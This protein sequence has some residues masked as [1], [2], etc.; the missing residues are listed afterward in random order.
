MTTDFSDADPAR[1]LKLLWG[2][3]ARPSRGPKPG[4]S[5]ERIVQAAI[6]IADAEGL[7]ALSMRR[8]GDHLGAGTMS[9]YRYVPGKT[10]LLA[11]MLD[12]VVGEFPP[13]ETT[14]GWR[15]DLER[16]ARNHWALYHRHPWTLQLPWN[17]PVPG[18]NMMAD[19]EWSLRTV[20]DLGLPEADVV[21]LVHAVVDYVRGAART[22]VEAMEAHRRGMS[23][24]RFWS[25]TGAFLDGVL[26][27]G[28]YP[29]VSR[30]MSA[31]D[32]PPY[33]DRIFEFGLQRVLDGIE[34]F[35]AARSTPPDGG[36]LSGT[37][38]PAAVNQG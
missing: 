19:Y 37:G 21:G 24:E 31:I 10:E 18:P 1:S 38:Q 35:I 7:A 3:R 33:G 12:A 4:L 29:A 14:G 9:L 15:A 6:D 32:E 26:Q 16:A 30:I 2:I 8:V 11:L 27:T 36:R 34:A 23:D 25:A 5:I 22:S 13:A 17:R 28:R 20:A